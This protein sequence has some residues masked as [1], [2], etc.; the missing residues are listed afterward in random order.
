MKRIAFI[1]TLALAACVTTG[2]LEPPKV[3]VTDVTLD[4]FT[5]PDARFTVKVKL[6]NPN[7]REL[8]VDALRAE[9]RLED[10]PVGTATLAAPVR[11]P[12]LGEATATVVA[13]ADLISSLRASGEIVRRLGREKSPSPAVRYTVS[14]SVTLQD[15]G[16]IPFS[17]AGEFKLPVAAPAR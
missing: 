8:A 4:Y 9:L 7:L 6:A 11:V 1:A 3:T 15:G 17:R 13:G 2:P 5:A 12:A 10:I 16:T 14:G